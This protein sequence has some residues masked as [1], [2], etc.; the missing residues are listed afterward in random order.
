MRNLP[1]VFTP[2][3]RPRLEPTTDLLIASPTLYHIAPR[4]H[5]LRVL[6]DIVTGYLLDVDVH[7]L[8]CLGDTLISREPP[9]FLV[10][11]PRRFA[12]PLMSTDLGQLSDGH[13]QCVV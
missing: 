13:L 2:R 10:L 8:Q 3:A 11:N 5:A 12:S 1:K 7:R 9:V 6:N 4:C